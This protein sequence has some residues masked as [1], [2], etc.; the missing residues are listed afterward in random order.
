MK[1]VNAI[2]QIL[3][4]IL[5]VYVYVCLKFNIDNNKLM[6]YNKQYIQ[7]EIMLHLRYG[8]T[9]SSYDVLEQDMKIDLSVKEFVTTLQGEDSS[10]IDGAD[11]NIFAIKILKALDVK[12]CKSIKVEIYTPQLKKAYKQIGEISLFHPNYETC[13]YIDGYNKVLTFN[14]IDLVNEDMEKSI[15]LQLNKA[16]RRML[17]ETY[18]MEDYI[19]K[20]LQVRKDAKIEEVKKED[21][22]F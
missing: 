10:V 18:N 4:I 11:L 22:T 21:I 19:A 3:Y 7:G 9:V 12:K 17:A 6:R 5:K 8:S 14:G 16:W 20:T 1:I 15:K 13:V 2:V